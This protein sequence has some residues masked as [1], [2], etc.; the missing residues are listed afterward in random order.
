MK[1]VCVLGVISIVIDSDRWHCYEHFQKIIISDENWACDMYLNVC[2]CNELWAARNGKKWN[3]GPNLHEL[4]LFHP[5]FL[6]KCS[7]R[8]ISMIKMVIVDK[9]TSISLIL[10]IEKLK[11][12]NP[13]FVNC[14]FIIHKI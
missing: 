1:I 8:E 9:S 7:F 14:T 13:K 5:Y 10:K 4:G 12:E 11:I 3:F 2:V 6:C